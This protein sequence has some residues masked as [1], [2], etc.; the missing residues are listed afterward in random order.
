MHTHTHIQS[1]QFPNTEKTWP[2][3]EN[4]ESNRHFSST[5]LSTVVNRTI[6]SEGSRTM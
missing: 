3:L 2:P 4:Q 5:F 1:Q 6:F